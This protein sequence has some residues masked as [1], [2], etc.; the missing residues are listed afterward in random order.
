M[1]D[2]ETLYLYKDVS[3]ELSALIENQEKVLEHLSEYAEK[4]DD[5]SEQLE[6]IIAIQQEQING[7]TEVIEY[8]HATIGIIVL[9]CFVVFVWNV[10]NK[11][12]FRGC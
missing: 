7:F 11:W 2:T 12:F 5:T 3:K 10:L 6:H 9:V 4:L 8:Q 1:E